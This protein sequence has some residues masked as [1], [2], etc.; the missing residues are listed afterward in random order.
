LPFEEVVTGVQAQW[1]GEE[2]ALQVHITRG[3]FQHNAVQRIRIDHPGG[4]LLTPQGLLEQVGEAAVVSG[5]TLNVI[6]PL[7]N[8]QQPIWTGLPISEMLLWTVEPR[9]DGAEGAFLVP[10]L[11]WD[12]GF[13]WR[14]AAGSEELLLDTWDQGFRL[15]WGSFLLE[16][17]PG[18]VTASAAPVLQAEDGRWRWRQSLQAYQGRWQQGRWRWEVEL[19]RQEGKIPAAA[20]EYTG[21]QWRLR[22]T[23]K[24]V[25]LGFQGARWSWGTSL[26]SKVVWLEQKE[27]MFRLELDPERVKARFRLGEK[28]RLGVTIDPTQIHLEL[29]HLPWEGYAKSSS[30]GWELG[31]TLGYQL[32]S[33]CTLYAEAVFRLSPEPRCRTDLGLVLMPLP[34][35][36]VAAGI[37]S[38]KG[39]HW[40][41]GI[42]LPL[43][44][45]ESLEECE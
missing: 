40:K 4:I 11:L 6:L 28:G 17:S 8:P 33:W 30:S 43:V 14:V 26:R 18:T 16:G 12:D 20:V 41:A 5:D 15:E 1:Q 45:R 23:P 3:W 31:Q 21:E 37:D 19:P 22:L 29:Q 10:I 42:V 9:P 39:L 2:S 38:E 44:S 13:S 35:T 25:S 27:R 7:E 32:T 24:D 36:V 34:Q